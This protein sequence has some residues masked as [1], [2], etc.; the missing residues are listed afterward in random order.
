MH[1]CLSSGNSIRCNGACILAKA[2]KQ[3]KTLT[4]LDISGMLELHIKLFVCGWMM[5]SGSQPVNAR[6]Y[7]GRDIWAEGACAL[8]E[9]LRQNTTLTQLNIKG[10]RVSYYLI[11]NLWCDPSHG[12]CMRV[13][14][15]GNKISDNGSCAIAK[16]LD[17]NAILP[18]L[19]L[20]CKPAMREQSLLVLPLI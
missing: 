10:K 19:N 15:S 20:I 14:P 9:A 13:N 12:L 8:A 4:Q 1:A 18:K 6:S 17:K 11:V 7:L 5:G 3:N 2:L 16:A